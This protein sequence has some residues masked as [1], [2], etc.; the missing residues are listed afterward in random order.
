MIKKLS[1]KMPKQA[2]INTYSPSM[3][4]DVYHHLYR[5]MSSQN[6]LQITVDPVTGL[7][8]AGD[9]IGLLIEKGVPSR[10]HRAT[11]LLNNLSDPMDY[12]GTKLTFLIPADDELDD[13]MVRHRQL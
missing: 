5:F 10:L 4:A 6:N 9:F 11:L 12:D 13:V 3:L 8:Y 2:P 7:R 1:D